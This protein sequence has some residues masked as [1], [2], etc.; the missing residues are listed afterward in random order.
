[1]KQQRTIGRLAVA[2]ARA[3]ATAALASRPRRPL[4]AQALWNL[5]HG[6]AQQM[7]SAATVACAPRS[8]SR[9]TSTTTAAHSATS[10]C[11]RR[12]R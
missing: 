6:R 8:G 9:S 1:M 10:G 12:S 2:A 11:G 3:A 5:R 7:L 4:A